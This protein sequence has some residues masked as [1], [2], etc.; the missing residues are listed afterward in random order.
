MVLAHHLDELGVHMLGEGRV[1]LK[2][3]ADALQIQRLHILHQRHAMGVAHGESSHLPGLALHRNGPV[4]HRVR[5]KALHRHQSRL[6][7]GGAHLHLPDALAP[8]GKVLDAC[9]RLD[10][11][12][13]PGHPVLIQ[14]LGHAADAV[15]AHGAL[16]AVGVEHAH[17]GV[18]HL[19]G[20]DADQPVR[21]HREPPG[22]EQPGQLGGIVD[23]ALQTIQ[24]NI[25]VAAAMHLGK[26]QPHAHPL[27][28]HSGPGPVDSSFIIAGF[29]PAHKKPAAGPFFR[30]A[31]ACF[32]DLTL[33][34]V[35]QIRYKMYSK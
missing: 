32:K 14:P 31:P 13:L 27:L 16:A 12:L 26:F 22:A 7:F 34:K 17:G 5:S 6:E 15:A 29:G 8:A 4:D 1:V 20:G 25:V 33:D 10:G 18:G 30:V 24:I 9:Q 21:P 23:H 2:A 11:H 19:G 3:G 35:P 28:S